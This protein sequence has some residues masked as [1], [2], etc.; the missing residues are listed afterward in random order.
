MSDT[1]PWWESKGVI[2]SIIVMAVLVLRLLGHEAEA[3]VIEGESAGI[4]TWWL[5]AVGL[6]AALLAFIGRLT[7]KK[8]L[9]LTK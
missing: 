9:T 1:K 5:E 6:V 4:A 7:A 2:G 3:E 8:D